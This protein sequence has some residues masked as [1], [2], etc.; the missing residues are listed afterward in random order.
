MNSGIKWIGGLTLAIAALV[1]GA[2]FVG[3]PLEAQESAPVTIAAQ[4]VLAEPAGEPDMIS[5]EVVQPQPAYDPED[6]FVIR[7]VLPID[8]PIRYGEWHW[9]DENVPPG[10]LVMTV[11]L[12]ARVLSVFRGG[13][14]IGAAAVLIGSPD[15]PTPTGVFPILTKERHNVSE[16]YNNAP[17]PWTMR[18]TWDGVAIHGG[19]TVERGYASHGCIGTPDAFVSKIYEIAKVGD[20]VI[21]TDGVQTGVGGSLE[22]G[23]G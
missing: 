13:Y 7:R 20:V 15:H 11:D 16:Q 5:R 23:E 18:L 22:H 14:E 6:P 1:G 21:I 8:G 9:D 2:T 12:Q 3:N 19:S 10:P 17:M 4:D